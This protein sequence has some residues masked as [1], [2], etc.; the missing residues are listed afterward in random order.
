ML[1]DVS[2]FIWLH[3]YNACLEYYNEH[4]NLDVP[5]D[6]VDENGVKLYL[7]MCSIRASRSGVKPNYRITDEQIQK[8]DELGFRWKSTKEIQ[9]ENGYSHAEEYFET[10]GNL[11]T[12]SLYESPDG[13]KLGNW[14]SVQKQNY[15]IGRLKK[16]RKEK[17]DKLG[18]VFEKPDSWE[19]RFSIAEEYFKEHH[20][21][22]SMPSNYQKDKICIGQWLSEQR[23]IY[24]GNRKGKSLT[25]EQIKRLESIGMYWDNKEEVIW[26]QQFEDVMEYYETHGDLDIP[27]DYCSKRGKLLLSWIKRQTFAYRHGNLSKEQIKQLQSIGIIRDYFECQ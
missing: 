6:Y 3:N 10:F 13:F 16:E 27:E 21:L 11:N 18:L 5:R 25:E 9:W 17:L 15:R 2:D 8:L 23:Q 22:L 20:D 26:Q 19:V 4:G 12:P 24:R 14:I 7:W 1:W